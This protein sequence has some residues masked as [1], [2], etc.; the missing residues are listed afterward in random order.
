MRII[1]LRIICEKKIIFSYTSSVKVNNSF[2]V[3]A[4]KELNAGRIG[5]GKLLNI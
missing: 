1:L 5:K 3:V 2:K 4:L